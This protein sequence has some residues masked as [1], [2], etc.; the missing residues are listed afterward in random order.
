MGRGSFQFVPAPAIRLYPCGRSSAVE[1]KHGPV[2]RDHP[3]AGE[4]SSLDAHA[5]PVVG[6]REPERRHDSPE[7]RGPIVLAPV[8]IQV[9]VQQQAPSDDG[10]LNVNGVLDVNGQPRGAGGRSDPLMCPWETRGS[11]ES[12]R[13]AGGSEIVC[14]DQGR[15]ADPWYAERPLDLGVSPDGKRLLRIGRWQSARLGRDEWQAAS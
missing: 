10:L 6:A 13:S 15:K 7:S 4:S 8:I 1:A 3:S 12:R 5:S 2:V 9:N 14:E 11:G